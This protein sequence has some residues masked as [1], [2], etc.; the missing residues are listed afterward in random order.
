MPRLS[1]EW[2][3]EAGFDE[4][5]PP[6]RHASTLLSL[7][8]GSLLVACFAGKAEGASDVGIWL[9]RRDP[10]GIWAPPLRVD[11][12]PGEAHWNPVLAQRRDGSTLIFYKVGDRIA[13]WRSMISES[14]DGV[15][16]SRPRELVPGDHGGRGPV[17]TK[18]LVLEEGIWLAG[19][20]LEKGPRWTAFIDR[21]TDEGRSW[22]RSADLEIDVSWQGHEDRGGSSIAVSD[23]SFHGRGL[24]QPSL[25]ED[26]VGVHCLIRSSEGAAYASDSRDGGFSWSAPRRSSI[27]NNNSGLDVVGLDDG[28][29][30][31]AHNPVAENWGARTPLVLSLSHDG[32][33]SWEGDLVL[34][35]GPGE[36]SYPA[37]VKAGGTLYASWTR[38][39][40]AIAVARVAAWGNS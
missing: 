31:L 11:A 8:D 35:D 2:I 9:A 19:A 16:W 15:V 6:S 7:G 38:D 33:A 20:S 14:R 4:T 32:G 30:V 10:R 25:W 24:I 37:L 5:V 21:S 26:S 13:S 12:E 29:L 18:I 1:I 28:T 40:R 36:F 34:E 27:P 3:E 23:Q 17:R 22:S 39:R